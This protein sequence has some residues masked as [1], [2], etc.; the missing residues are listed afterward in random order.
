[1]AKQPVGWAVI[2]TNPRIL[3]ATII[4]IY[5]RNVEG[6]KKD[7]FFALPLTTGKPYRPFEES[8]VIFFSLA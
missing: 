7:G 8:S 4:K 1:L 3:G 6:S 5:F 2:Q